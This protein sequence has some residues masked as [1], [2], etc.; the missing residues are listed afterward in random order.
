MAPV[1]CG[2]TRFSDVAQAEL[3]G[4][5]GFT[6]VRTAQETFY[7][8]RGDLQ[9]PN[10]EPTAV[11]WVTRTSEVDCYRFVPH[12]ADGDL[13]T[14]KITIAGLAFANSLAP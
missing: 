14:K 10:N 2:S 7:Q 6:G 13:K 12:T 9:D 3:I 1:H 8:W 11:T 5:L 4:S